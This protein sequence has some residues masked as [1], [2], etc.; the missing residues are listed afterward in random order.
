MYALAE[1]A[2]I[3][4]SVLN[5]YSFVWHDACFWYVED[6]TVFFKVRS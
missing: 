6:G 1:Q 3:I 4:T 5:F 2:A